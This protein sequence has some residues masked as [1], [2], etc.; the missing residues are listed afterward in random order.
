MTTRALPPET[1]R[2]HCDPDQFNF[3]TTDELKDLEGFI[4]QER[5][6]ES[7]HFGLGVEHKGYNLYALGPAGA[8]KS[9]MVRKFLKALAA[10][11]PIPSDWCY[12]NNFSDARKPRAVSLPAGKGVMF[13]E[14]M[15]QLVIGLQEAIP[16][17]FESDEYHTRRQAKEDRLEERQENAMAAMQKKAEEKHIALINTPTGFTLGPKQNDKILGPEQF[18]KLPEKEQAAIEKDVKALQEELRRTLHAIPQWQKEAREEISKLNREM[19]ASAVHHLIDAVREKYRDNEAVIV[20]LDRVE[21]D[22]INNYQQFLPRDERKPTLFGL[23]L[24]QQEEGPPWHY[25]YR[26]NLL[27]AH[28]ANG[29]APIVYEDLPGY[30]NLVGRIEHRAH[31]G[32]LETD[33]TMIRPGALHRANG[34]YLI[35]DALKLLFQP[36]AWETL[37]RVL[38]SGEIRIESLAQITSLISTQ[39]LEPEP[40]PLQVKVVL[41]GERHIYYLLQALDPEFDEL[42]KVAVDFDDD[43]VRDSHNEHQ[44]GQLVATLARQHKL[45]PLDR[46]AVARVIDHSMRLA[47]DNERLSSHM[48][49]LTDLIQQADFW[50]GEQE[51]KLISRD[52]VQQAIEARIHRAD[53]VQRRLQDE[54]V[55]GTL[56][57]ATDGEVVGQINGLSVM[58]LGDQRFGHPNRITARARLGKGQVVDIEREVELGGPIHSKGVY[59]LSGFIAGRYVP[60]YPLSLS[61]SLVFEQSYGGVEGDSASS[62]E[63]YALL[64]AL[65]GLPIKQQFAVTG[66]VNQ[67]GEVQA[68]G[69]VNEKIEGFFDICRTRGLSGDQGVLIPTAN[70]KHLM[71]REDVVQAVKVGEFAVY[72][73]DNIDQGIALLTGAP[74]GTRDENGEFPEDSVNGRVEASLIRF[75]ERMQSTGEMA[76]MVTGEDQ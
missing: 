40:I 8:G 49:S 11:R 18:H 73:I 60:D 66:S 17:V 7:L 12:V 25:R 42:F 10:E 76:I 54:V 68:I 41:L 52:D 35:L 71:L 19:T 20:Y 26:V 61:A 33:F 37:K 72:P 39:S 64:S 1:L 65:S 14:E 51:H 50:A 62:A 70:I 67:M 21:D 38:Q 13:K 63:L 44:Y 56:M 55:R 74:A 47:D 3:D 27:L 30:N 31:L 28:E 58:L 9:A 36:F 43:L 22:V 4:G 59:I 46:Y 6:T 45:R 5:A 15:E 57:I 69:G 23:P 34:G 32:A 53:R 2:R 29:G 48:R 24:S 75:S 16:L